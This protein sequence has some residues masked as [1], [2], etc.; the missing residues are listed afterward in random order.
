MR[1]GPDGTVRYYFGDG[2]DGHA[3][4]VLLGAF[5]HVN[6]KYGVPFFVPA[7]SPD[8]AQVRITRRDAG[9]R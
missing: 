7:S 3:K 5:Q 8:A 6:E 2:M 1:P 4:A 9:I